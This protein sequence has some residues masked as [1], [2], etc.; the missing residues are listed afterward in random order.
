MTKVIVGLFVVRLGLLGSA[1]ATQM[2]SPNL[3]NL[4]G[5]LP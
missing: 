2:P 4:S 5:L 1:L 3:A